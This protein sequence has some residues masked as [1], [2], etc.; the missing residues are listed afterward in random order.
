MPLI[1]CGGKYYYVFIIQLFIIIII[2]IKLFNNY[3][4]ISQVLPDDRDGDV[5]DLQRRLD[6]DHL[7]GPRQTQP[8]TRNVESFRNLW[9]RHRFVPFPLY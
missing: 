6:A 4:N 5:C 3:L 7:Q 1:P 2:I 9:H 8:Q